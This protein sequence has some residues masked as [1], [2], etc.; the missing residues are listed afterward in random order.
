MIISKDSQLWTARVSMHLLLQ[1]SDTGSG[2]DSF[3][4]VLTRPAECGWECNDLIDDILVWCMYPYPC[5]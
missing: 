3:I 2:N 4:A 5:D 1:D